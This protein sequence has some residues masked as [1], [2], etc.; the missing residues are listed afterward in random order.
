MSLNLPPHYNYV[1]VFLTLSCNLRC[2]YC[3]NHLSGKARG[4]RHLN[5]VEWIAA[6][7]RLD[8][9]DSLPITFQG[10]EPSLHP[11]FFEILG[12]LRDGLKIDLLT[13]LQFDPY[14][15]IKEVPRERLTRP[16]PY[17]SIRVS[18]HPETMELEPLLEKVTV[19]IRHGYSIGVYGVLHPSYADTVLSAQKRAVKMGIDFRTKEFLGEFDGKLHGP[20]KHP[21]AVGG[22]ALRHCQC[23][24]SELLVSPNGQV[25][26]CHHDLYNELLPVGSIADPLFEVEDIFR[27]CSFFGNCNPCDIKLKT[28]RFQVQ[29]HHSVEI[30]DV[31]PPLA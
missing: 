2:S 1:A 28:N 15:L 16:A 18:Y 30:R 10:G 31:K 21:E 25:H 26:R 12:G 6:L 24:T 20:F 4:R 27:P 13:N 29:G 3:I 11:G 7:N 22:K 14:R 8:L 19:L 5:A 23:K 17:P 9:I